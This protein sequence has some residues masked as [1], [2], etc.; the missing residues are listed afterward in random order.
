MPLLF[1]LRNVPEDEA[2]AVRALFADNDIA[3]R[4]TSGGLLGLGTAAIWVDGDGD[5]ARASKLLNHY[6]EQR[7]HSAQAQLSA[8]KQDDQ[9]P[10]LW[11]NF[12]QRPGQFLIY[13]LVVGG[14]IYLTIKPFFAIN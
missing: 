4:E 12:K 7:Y 11:R 9:H 14:I 1:R 2:D 6:Q 13:L 3:F 10:T 5:F 8:A